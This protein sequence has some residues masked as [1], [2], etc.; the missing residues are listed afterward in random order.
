MLTILRRALFFLAEREALQAE[1]SYELLRVLDSVLTASV[2]HPR[3]AH[4]YLGM[5]QRLLSPSATLKAT[6]DGLDPNVE[7]DSKL[8]EDDDEKWDADASTFDGRAATRRL[9]VLRLALARHLA[10]TVAM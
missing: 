5:L 7:R 10:R 3:Q 2:G 4:Y 1:E 6:K 8:D 9:D